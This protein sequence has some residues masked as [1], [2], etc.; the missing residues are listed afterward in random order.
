MNIQENILIEN[1]KQARKNVGLSGDDV[2]KRIGKSDNSYISRVENGKQKLNI[3]LINQ[4]CDVY[5]INPL[6]LFSVSGTKDSGPKGFLNNLDYRSKT[7]AMSETVK[8]RIKTIL[9]TLRKIGKVMKRLN[10][11]PLNLSDFYQQKAELLNPTSIERAKGIGKDIAI[12]LREYLNLGNDPIA[13]ICSLIWHRLNVPMCSLKLDDQ[14]WGIY[15]RDS[16]GNPLII[17]SNSHQF[18]QRNIFTIT[19]ELGH[20][21]F[22]SGEPTIDSENNTLDIKET[23]ANS[24]AQ[25]FL[26][27]E[28][29]LYEYMKDE[30]LLKITLQKKHVVELCQYFKVSYLMML[31]VL[32][33]EG[34]ISSE[35]YKILSK[36]TTEEL[37]IYGYVPNSFTPNPITLEDILK[38]LVSKGLRSEKFNTLF[39]SEILEK[40]EKEIEAL[41]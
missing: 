41:V 32:K 17:F 33:D 30:G 35:T 9:P 14:C 37:K 12:K 8:A 4:L 2:A 15:N 13:D 11:A 16:F 21:F 25:K 1:L 38:R 22:S 39:A 28:T 31:I 26:V 7:N 29:A 20:H 36:Y 3:E 24:F 34:F 19:H 23:L 18:A 10:I 27:P 40:T 5:Q 6:A